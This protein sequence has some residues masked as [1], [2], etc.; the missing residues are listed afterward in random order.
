MLRLLFVSR[1]T[2]SPPFSS[3]LTTSSRL[4]IIPCAIIVSSVSVM[5]CAA[6]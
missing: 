5:A 3:A 4:R 6:F 2:V 1:T